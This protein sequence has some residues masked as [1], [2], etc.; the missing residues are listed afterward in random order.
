MR[1]SRRN[2]DIMQRMQGYFVFRTAHCECRAYV[3]RHEVQPFRRVYGRSSEPGGV[4]NGGVVRIA[5]E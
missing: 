2:G 4:I 3:D 5:P 1:C